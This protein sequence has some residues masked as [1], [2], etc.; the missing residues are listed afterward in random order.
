M[1]LDRFLAGL[2]RE[3]AEFE[4]G[5]IA[6][7]PEPIVTEV[8]RPRGDK[9]TRV[10]LAG[11]GDREFI[12]MNSNSYLG[13]SVRE[14]VIKAAE[15]GAA[16]YGAGPGAVRF[17]S[18][19]YEPH[20]RLE[21]RLAAFHGRED[22][23]LTNSAYTSV[24]G[25]VVT[26]TTPETII[27]S[28]ELN[29]N[30]IISAVRLARPKDRIVYKHLDMADLEKRIVASIGKGTTVL[31]ITDGIFSMRGEYAPLD[32]IVE[33]AKRHDDKYPRGILVVVDD[34]HGVGALGQTGRGTEELTGVHADVL[35]ATLGKALAVNGGYIVSEKDVLK[36]LRQKNPLY[37]YTNPITPA[38]AMSA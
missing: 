30:C 23:M 24:M 21:Q 29:H 28:D 17:I 13:L 12:R 36:Y 35:V 7:G 26:L 16:R 14:E 25:V 8:I 1:P 20:T 31:I 18:G 38:E 9:G 27:I 11:C 2:D 34:S 6:K 22:C 32:R 4:A 37:I 15:G 33:L 5:G 19:T 10:R 3:L